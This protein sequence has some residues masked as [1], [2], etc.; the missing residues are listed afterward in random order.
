MLSTRCSPLP[1]TSILLSL[2]TQGYVNLL[3]DCGPQCTPGKAIWS[4]LSARTYQNV[5]HIQVCK[6]NSIGTTLFLLPSQC[7]ARN[8]HSNMCWTTPS[9]REHVRGVDQKSLFQAE[10]PESKAHWRVSGSQT[11][12]VPHSGF[13]RLWKDQ[14]G[15]GA[16]QKTKSK[17][18][19]PSEN[20]FSLRRTAES[21]SW[22]AGKNTLEF[23]SSFC[24]KLNSWLGRALVNYIWACGSLPSLRNFK[25]SRIFRQ[26]GW[27]ST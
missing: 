2:Q 13:S 18:T 6:S 4:L 3:S 9:I 12:R 23:K 11:R 21:V 5:L 24:S 22:I 10:Q 26:S 19:N 14:P 15:A 1:R 27:L 16:Q 7:S 20:P 8:W 25:V 17:P